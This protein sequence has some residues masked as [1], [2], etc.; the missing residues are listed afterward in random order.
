M[1]QSRQFFLISIIDAFNESL[2]YERP[3]SIYGEPL[4]WLNNIKILKNYNTKNL[5]LNLENKEKAIDNNS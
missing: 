3:G 5:K 4:P 1:L 2:E